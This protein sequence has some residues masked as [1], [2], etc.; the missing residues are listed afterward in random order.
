MP[1]P[2]GGNARATRYICAT[3]IFAPKISDATN[4]TTDDQ[5]H[6]VL[7]QTPKLTKKAPKDRGKNL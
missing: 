2:T 3:Q 7:S 5:P 1:P 6:R 4:I